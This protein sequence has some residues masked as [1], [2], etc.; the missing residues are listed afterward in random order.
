MAGRASLGGLLRDHNRRWLLGYGKFVGNCS[1]FVAEALGNVRWLEYDNDRLPTI[2]KEIRQLLS[3][4]WQV[5]FKHISKRA[6]QV[7]TCIGSL[8][9]H[10]VTKLLA[11]PA[12]SIV[13]LYLLEKDAVAYLE[14]VS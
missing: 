7:A 4:N 11:F 8:L 5:N 12:P 10:R 13:A 9:L 14:F 2:V 3:L 1:I 6:N